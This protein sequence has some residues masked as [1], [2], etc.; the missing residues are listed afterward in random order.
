MTTAARGKA[1]H[2]FF[3]KG[4]PK[5]GIGP[6]VDASHY[7]GGPASGQIRTNQFM[8]PHWTLREFK[9]YGGALFRRQSKSN[10]GNDLLFVHQKIRA[11]SN[12]QII[13]LQ[14]M[15]W[16][17]LG[18]VNEPKRR[19]RRKEYIHLRIRT[20]NAGYSITLIALRA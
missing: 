2:D 7:A 8:Q 5:D 14:K 6:V 16:T 3:L 18:V 20:N 12:S 11:N 13:W 9:T 19:S 1:L 17:I 4:L 10:P 15:R